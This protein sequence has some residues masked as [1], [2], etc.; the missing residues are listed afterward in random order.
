LRL[1]V[2][3]CRD[4]GAHVLR[5]V[6]E[7]NPVDLHARQKLDR[8]PV[9][10]CDVLEIKGDATARI[11]RE[12]LLQSSGVLAI[13]VAKQKLSWR[14]ESRKKQAF[15]A[16][17]A[18]SE[19]LV[20]ACCR[21]KRVYAIDRTTRTEVWSFT[22]DGRLD[23]SPVIAGNRVYVGSFDKVLYVLD[24]AS[25]KEVQRLPLDSSIL[26][27]PALADGR[28]VVGTEKGTVYCLGKP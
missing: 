19:K 25:G 20:V 28:L 21:D 2:S 16:S 22:T 6:D 13:D 27:S 11:A 8:R 3:L 26:G 4:P 14:F 17:P 9:D 24:L 12:E 10:Q 5:A 18:V 1:A 15:Y 23:S 7:S